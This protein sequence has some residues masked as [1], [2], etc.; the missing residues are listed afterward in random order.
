MLYSLQMPQGCDTAM[1]TNSCKCYPFG[2]ALLCMHAHSD[3]LAGSSSTAYKSCHDST[4]T[5]QC[6]TE[7]VTAQTCLHVIALSAYCNHEHQFQ[8]TCVDQAHF[9]CH[10]VFGWLPE[11][12]DVIDFAITVKSVYKDACQHQ[13]HTSTLHAD[14]IQ[15]ST[16]DL[17]AAEHDVPA[18]IDRSIVDCQHGFNI[19]TAG[20]MLS[21]QSTA[22][23]QV[24]T[25]LQLQNT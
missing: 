23:S 2:R 25:C 16:K 6:S 21:S 5:C 8:T 18:E 17:F 12:L 1:S 19:L 14:P 3:V 15:N 10:L 7:N 9:A 24:K 22:G 11:E 13:K 20:H 4:E